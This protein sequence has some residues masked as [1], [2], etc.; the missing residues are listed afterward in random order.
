NNPVDR[1]EEDPLRMLRAVRLAGELDFS[2]HKETI[3]AIAFLSSKIDKVSVERV[4][5]EL[6]RI[7]LCRKPPILL[8]LMCETG[9]MKYIL[10]EI[11]EG[12]GMKQNSWHLY[13]V[14]KHTVETV[15]NVPSTQTLRLAAL[16]H[17][18]GKP[19][20]RA[21]IDGEYHFYNHEGVSSSMA[22]EI[23]ERLRFSNDEIKKITALISFHMFDYKEEWSDAAV[24]RLIKRAGW[25]NI[26]ELLELRK[27]DIIAHGYIDDKLDLINHL[28]QRIEKMR[29]EK[30]SISITDLAIDGKKVMDI[31]GI[32]PGPG[33][34]KILGKLLE[35]VIDDPELNS[36][37]YLSD[38]LS[39]FKKDPQ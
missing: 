39:E 35:L 4:R 8:E 33:V 15:T 32:E 26:D 19:R 14:F 28:E 10:P 34:G 17:D 29:K 1:F 38:I 21:E 11:L 13:T 16:L 12:K 24:R 5:D 37:R 18:I 36:E 30:I 20:V 2:I 27:A 7:I 3:D 31:M 23:M 9:L 25:D 22:K 6:V